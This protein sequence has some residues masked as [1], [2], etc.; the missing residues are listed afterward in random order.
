[1]ERSGDEINRDK[2]EEVCQDLDLDL[3]RHSF[4]SFYCMHFVQNLSHVVFL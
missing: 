3:D 1:M 2:A 4:P